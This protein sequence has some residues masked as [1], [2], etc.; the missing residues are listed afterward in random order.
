[1]TRPNN[2][3]VFL[4]PVG[5]GDDTRLFVPIK[6]VLKE[7]FTPDLTALGKEFDS[8]RNR[9]KREA[10]K[11]YHTKEQKVEVFEKWQEFMKEISNNVP[12][13]EYYIYYIYIYIYT[14]VHVI[15][16]HIIKMME[17]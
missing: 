2:F 15:I 8:E 7:D 5:F 17:V 16:F 10:Y 11:A 1:M 3:L 12:F 13:F 4:G 9:V 14:H 6:M